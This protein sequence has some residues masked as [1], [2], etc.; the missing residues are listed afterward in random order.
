VRLIII[1]LIIMKLII[2]GRPASVKGKT[3]HRKVGV[4][5]S[6]GRIRVGSGPHFI[7]DRDVK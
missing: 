3:N 2:K 4:A 5:R 1:I 7:R 6:R